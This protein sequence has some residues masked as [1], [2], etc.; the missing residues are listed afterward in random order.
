QGGAEDR[1]PARGAA[2]PHAGR[3]GRLTAPG[4]SDYDPI[5]F[6]LPPL[7]G[8][9]AS[10]RSIVYYGPGRT[11]PSPE[12]VAFARARGLGVDEA[13]SADEVSAMLN[14]SFPACLVLDARSDAEPVLELCRA[15]KKD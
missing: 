15:M 14:W 12:I 9:M 5:P 1:L 6:H 13:A 4:R 3:S 8:R 7:P 10:E 2:P 11:G